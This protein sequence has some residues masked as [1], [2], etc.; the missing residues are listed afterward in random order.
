MYFVCLLLFFFNCL[1]LVNSRSEEILLLCDTPPESQMSLLENFFVDNNLQTR[2]LSQA[3]FSKLPSLM[4][5]SIIVY[6]HKPFLAPVEKKLIDFCNDG[7]RLVV[8]HHAIASAKMQ[9]QNWLPF[10]GVG[11]TKDKTARFPWTVLVNGTFHMVNLWPGHFVTTNKMQYDAT[12]SYASSDQPAE[13]CSFQAF[14]LP[15]T[16]LLMNQMFVDGRQKTVLFGYKFIDSV[17]GKTF[18][19]DRAGWFVKKNKGLLFYFVAGHCD[20]DFLNK[21]FCQVILNSLIFNPDEH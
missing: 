10:C 2:Q 18:M 5:K 8:L 9:N 20:A 17:S 13:K 4:N 12:V 7:G 21:S 11:L 14:T 3:D 6:V 15:D 1:F 16:E 19:A